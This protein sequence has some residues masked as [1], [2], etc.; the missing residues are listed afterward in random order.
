MKTKLIYVI[1]S[2]LTLFLFGCSM[3]KSP[4][5]SESDTGWTLHYVT[6][7]A[8]GAM[9]VY[10]VDVD[11]DG[12]MDVLSASWE[13]NKIAWYENDGNE[14]FTPHIITTNANGARS[15]YAVDVDGDEDMDVLSAS[16][17][18]DKIA[19]YENLL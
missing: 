19:W 11:S 10:A 16:W 15:V 13:D 17:R 7:S 12:D 2:V 1:L 14:S 5:E 8:N 3:D 9:S 18:D 4:T 6:S